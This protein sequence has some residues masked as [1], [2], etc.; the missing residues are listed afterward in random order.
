[1]R[2]AAR[3]RLGRDRTPS[4]DYGL[5]HYAHKTPNLPGLAALLAAVFIGARSGLEDLT[6]VARK[7]ETMVCLRQVGVGL[8]IRTT[9]KKPIT[10]C[11]DGLCRR[12]GRRRSAQGS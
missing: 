7:V 4:T 2:H 10:R 1:M 9:R 6:L 8:T 11:R 3:I 12:G 5:Q